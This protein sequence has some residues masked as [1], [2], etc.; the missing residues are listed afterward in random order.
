VLLE[1]Q[2][3]RVEARVAEM[4]RL[5]LLG[6]P[7][8]ALQASIAEVQ[9]SLEQVAAALP[10]LCGEPCQFRLTPEEFCAEFARTFACQL[11]R[12]RGRRW[13]LLTTHRHV[14]A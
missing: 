13:R 8:N 6:L 2:L 10:G 5:F 12:C 4:R 3:A 9:A 14:P 7:Y 1:E 11:S